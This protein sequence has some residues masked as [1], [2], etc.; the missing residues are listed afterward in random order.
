MKSIHAMPGCALALAASIAVPAAAQEHT[1]PL[2]GSVSLRVDF[3]NDPYIRQVL[4]GGPHDAAT[5]WGDNCAGFV[6]SAPT[7]VLNYRAGNLPLIISVASQ[8]DT[9]LIIRAP[10]GSNHCDDDGGANG[11]NPGLRFDRPPSGRYQIWVGTYGRAAEET[12]AIH[13]SENSTQ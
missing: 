13:I 1:A 11:M 8:A 3:P 9:T 12:A 10:D 6:T 2:Y 4:S 5:S 7:F